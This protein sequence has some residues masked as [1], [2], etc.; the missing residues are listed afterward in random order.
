MRNIG[1]RATV[2][3]GWC[4]L[5]G[6]HKVW[7]DGVAQQDGHGALGIDVFGIDR[8]LVAAVSNDDIAEPFLQILQAGSQAQN[9]HHL[10]CDRDIET[11][12][13]RKPVGYCPETVGDFA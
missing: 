8:T 12:C 3:E 1:E 7:L 5:H 10:G 9:R 6:L 13:A 11:V 2:N 4:A